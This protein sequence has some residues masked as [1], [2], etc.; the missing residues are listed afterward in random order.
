MAMASMVAVVAVTVLKS[1]TPSPASSPLT[2]AEAA[3]M[4]V[5]AEA[6]PGVLPRSQ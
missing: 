4:A 5:A 3:T 6:M 2:A 1:L